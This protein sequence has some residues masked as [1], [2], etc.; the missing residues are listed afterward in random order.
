MRRA[1]S[2]AKKEFIHIVRDPL[3][4]GLVLLMPVIMLL[5]FGYAITTEVKHVPTVVWDQDKSAASR[6]LIDAFRGSQYFDFDYHAASYEEVARLIDSG[7]AKAGLVIPPDY[8]TRL[9][10]RE[11]ATVQFF[12][13]GSDPLIA[14]KVLSYATII[15]Q[16]N[17]IKLI[18]EGWGR[19]IPT[20]LDFRPRVWYNPG[21]ETIAFTVP[22]LVG[23]VL[24]WIT[25]GLTAAAIVR[26][27]ERGT[28]EQ[29]IVS[30]IKPIELVLGKIACYVAIAFVDAGLALLVAI[31]WFGMPMH[32]SLSLLFAL[33]LVFMT[34]SLGVGLFISTV[35]KSHYQA[36][37]MVTF[38]MLPTIMLS[39][40]VTP[41]EAMPKPVQYVT[42]LLPLRYYLRIIRGIVLKGLGL[43]LLWKEALPLALYGVLALFLSTIRFRKT[44]E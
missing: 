31:G 19:Q 10:R 14:T 4:L 18:A 20:P 39:G 34:F 44:L 6:R 33:S 35:A 30:P 16:A 22:G 5:L 9:K 11:T 37:Q 25:L 7:K 38:I 1:A 15:A 12:I 36:M 28:L 27:R 2:V 29:L 26:E 13:D 23:V 21:M 40:F 32:G 24:Q 41:I 8:A 3:T 42:Y 43:S 17:S